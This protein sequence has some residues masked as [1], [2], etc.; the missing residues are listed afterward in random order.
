MR[1]NPSSVAWLLCSTAHPLRT[2]FAERFGPRL[3]EAA[4]AAMR[5]RRPAAHRRAQRGADAEGRVSWAGFDEAA[6]RL[7]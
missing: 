7:G 4:A 5:P 1:P 2:R 6:V 3:S